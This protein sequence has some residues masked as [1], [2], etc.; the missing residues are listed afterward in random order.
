MP[1]EDFRRDKD[2]K[3]LLKSIQPETFSGESS[4][5]ASTLKEWIIAMDDYFSLAEYNFIAQGI[6]AQAKFTESEKMWW[7][8]NCQ[9]SGVLE[10][11]QS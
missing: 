2:L 5:V 6:R 11:T 8:L 1:K 9:S 4:N 3:T 10:V 7:K